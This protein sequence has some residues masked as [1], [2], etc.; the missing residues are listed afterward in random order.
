MGQYWKCLTKNKDGKKVWGLQVVKPEGITKDDKEYWEHYNGVKL[1][2]HSWIGN[3]FMTAISKYIYKN[4]TKVAWV[5]DYADTFRWECSQERPSPL[6]L[7][8]E[9]WGEGSSEEE[10][11]PVK[12]FDLHDKYLVNHTKKVAL[13]FNDYIDNCTDGEWC[14]HPL[15]LLTACG[16]GMG[17][18]DFYDRYI[19]ACDVGWW[20]NDE[21]SIEDKCPDGYVIDEIEFI[22]KS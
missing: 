13:D 17:G 14:I 1:M 5:G 16:N 15:S 21:I 18:G 4:P 12:E 8:I 22:E 20:C 7:W 3:S 2:E 11:E 6:E 10:I 9:T 19:G